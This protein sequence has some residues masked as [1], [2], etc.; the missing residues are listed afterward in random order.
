[1][2]YF[3][4]TDPE[5]RRAPNETH[6]D[7]LCTNPLSWYSNNETYVDAS[8]S[9]GG[10]HIVQWMQN[11]YFLLG[12][13]PAD[14]QDLELTAM[15]TGM[16]ALTDPPAAT[17]ARIQTKRQINRVKSGLLGLKPFVVGARCQNG[18]LFVDP[19]P[20]GE[21]GSS[22]WYTIFP[23]WRF[24][25]FPAANLHPYDF[26]YFWNNIRHNAELRAS[27]LFASS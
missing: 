18:S 25:S 12:W 3:E 10:M 22:P 4:A 14:D 9:R 24:G 15:E 1:M 7:R 13:T 8:H 6:A 21:W 11:L 16:A 2:F 19:P 26:N 23:A 5:L 17:L 20:R 27:R